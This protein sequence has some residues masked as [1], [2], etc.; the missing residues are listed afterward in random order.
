MRFKL[1]SF[2]IL[3]ILPN[4]C[5]FFDHAAYLKT[6]TRYNFS[7]KSLFSSVLGKKKLISENSNFFYRKYRN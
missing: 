7:K 5:V 1:K 2:K 4:G 6:H 3:Q